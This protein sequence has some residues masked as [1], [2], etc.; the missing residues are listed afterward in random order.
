[1]PILNRRAGGHGAVHLDRGVHRPDVLWI[2]RFVLFHD[3]QHPNRMGEPEVVR[4]LRKFISHLALERHV[5]AST[6]DQIPP[7][8]SAFPL[9][10]VF[11][12]FTQNGF[13]P[14]SQGQH[15]VLQILDGQR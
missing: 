3:K 7:D 4:F 2:R 8:S 14:L 12:A 1:V 11:P 15:P 6:Q 13:C 9:S 5:A 10:Q